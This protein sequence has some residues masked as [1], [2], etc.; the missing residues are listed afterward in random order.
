MGADVSDRAGA[1]REERPDKE[2]P[3]VSRALVGCGGVIIV[4]MVVA[5]VSALVTQV[6]DGDPG[7]EGSYAWCT[8]R[9]L[10]R[11]EC[12]IVNEYSAR[13]GESPSEWLY[14]DSDGDDPESVAYQLAII[15]GAGESA[16]VRYDQ[17]LRRAGLK[18]TN[19]EQDIADMSVRAVQLLAENGVELSILEMLA[20]PEE[21]IPSEAAPLECAEVAA[22][23]VTLTTSG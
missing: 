1:G 21:A 12:D 20:A 18:C 19:S 14:D 7:Q 3:R 15:D 23:I 9:G 13:N 22:L 17:A 2:E 10:D 6:T 5:G 8:R 16:V 4:I 11:A